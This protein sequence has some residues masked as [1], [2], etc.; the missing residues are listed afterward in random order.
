MP[1]PPYT[2]AHLVNDTKPVTDRW[3]IVF[4]AWNALENKKIRKRCY[5]VNLLKTRTE[6]LTY[7]KKRIA[8]INALLEGEY[9]FNPKKAKQENVALYAD[10]ARDYTINEAFKYIS[11]II[12][13]S[14]RIDTYNSYQSLS[15]LF[16]AFCEDAGWSD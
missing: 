16:L 12:K 15:N 8:A 3:Y 13:N 10:R 1:T 11:P 9:H 6:R 4:W 7:A 5:K 2:P 14:K